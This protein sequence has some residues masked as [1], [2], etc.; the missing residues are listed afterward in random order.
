MHKAEF[1]GKVTGLPWRNRSCS[2]EGV[3]CW[4]LIVLFYRHVMGK[5][6]HDVPGYESDAEFL[7]CFFNEIVFWQQ[8]DVFSD[9]DMFVA[10]YGSTPVHVGLIIDG[11]ALHSRGESGHVRSDHIRTVQK[12]YTKI[13]YYSYADYRDST[14]TGPAKAES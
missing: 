8:S 7:T 5:E 13:E 6:L 1:I 10:Y 2:F 3:D 11:M 9:G 12:L 14:R 4:G